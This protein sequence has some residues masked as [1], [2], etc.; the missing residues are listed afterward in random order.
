VALW[1]LFIPLLIVN[2]SLAAGRTGYAG[3]EKHPAVS[4]TQAEIPKILAVLESKVENHELLETAKKKL[5]TFDH[6]QT[7][8]LSSLCD[9]ITDDG[10]T[11][12]SDVAFLL[13]MILIVLS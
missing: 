1:V 9:R 2:T 12:G 8:L 13:M 10:Q 5:Q 11:A 6:N 4:G 3:L 7:Q